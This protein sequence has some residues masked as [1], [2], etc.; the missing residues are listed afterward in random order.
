MNRQYAHLD[1]Y[2][3]SVFGFVYDQLGLNS[4]KPEIVFCF[5]WDDPFVN[6][7]RTDKVRAKELCSSFQSAL[8]KVYLLITTLAYVGFIK[9]I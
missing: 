4:V 5:I 6:K 2:L 7:L 9:L 1:K 8:G 3:M